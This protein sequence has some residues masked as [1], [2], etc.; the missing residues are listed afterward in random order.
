MSNIDWQE[1]LV[2]G[3]RRT[4]IQRIVGIIVLAVVLGFGLWNFFFASTPEYALNQLNKAIQTKDQKTITKYCNLESICGKAYD[5]LTRDM[6][7]HDTKLTDNT[8]VMFETFYMKIK[9]QLVEETSQ[10]ILDYIANDNWQSP[11]GNNIL[12]GRQLGIDYEFLIERSQLRNTELVKIDHITRTGNTAIAK[13]QVRDKYTD[14]IFTLQLLMT[15]NDGTWQVTE[16]QNYRGYLDFLGPIQEAGLKKYISATSD[17]VNKYNSILDTQQTRFKKLSQSGD[18]ILTAS[19]R[20]KIVSYVRS[21]IIPA[22]EKRQEELDKVEIND[23][24]Q[25]IAAQRKES[26]RLSVA[27]WG[28]F[29][30]ALETDTPDEFNIADSFHKDSLDVDHRIDDIIKNTAISRELPSIP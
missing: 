18:G 3:R 1:M 4:R 29:I 8:K 15:K 24:A 20:S 21:D 11:T 6:F 2:K 14:T 5:D 19:M 9:P 27:A 12:K 23:G 26:T 7:A 22:L 17:I 30:T 28:H 25:Y 16:I 13:V 10:L